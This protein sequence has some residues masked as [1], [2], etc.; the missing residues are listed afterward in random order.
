MKRGMVNLEIELAKQIPGAKILLQI[1]DELLISVPEAQ[2]SQAQALA[3]KTLE[4]VV[5]WPVPLVV[6]TRTGRDWQEVTK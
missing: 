5:S 3:K 6:D 4:N 1:H 2:I